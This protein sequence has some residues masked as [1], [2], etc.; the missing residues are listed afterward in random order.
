MA[1]VLRRRRIRRREN[2]QDIGEKEAGDAGKRRQSNGEMIE[3]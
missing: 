2:R 1:S 3:D